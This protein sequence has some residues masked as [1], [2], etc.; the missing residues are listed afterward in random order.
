MPVD[1]TVVDGIFDEIQIEVRSYHSAANFGD[2]QEEFALKS[3]CVVTS[4]C[5]VVPSVHV[6]FK[7]LSVI[8]NPLYRMAVYNV[9][10]LI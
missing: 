5:H 7:I 9:R 10:K 6:F 4:I 8:Y 2:N 3:V 1:S